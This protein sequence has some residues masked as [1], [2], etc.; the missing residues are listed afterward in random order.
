MRI[1]ARIVA[2]AVTVVGAGSAVAQP[3]PTVTLLTYNV[4][5]LPWPIATGRRPALEAIANRLVIMRREGRQ[6]HLVALQ[7]AFIPDAKAI[8]RT[9]GY[10][11]EAFGPAASEPGAQP[12]TPQDKAFLHDASFTI[13]ERAGKR[14]DSG[15]V[16]FSDYP[17]V[18]VHRMA[19]SM[20]AGY[21]CLA[22]K[23]VLA[24]LVA[25]PGL[26]TPLIVIDTHLNSA[27]ASGAPRTRS[28]Y[29]YD[30]QID[31]LNGFIA[32]LGYAGSPTLIAGDFNVGNHTDRKEYFTSHLL[33]SSSRLLA[34]EQSCAQSKECGGGTTG[35]VEESTARGKDWLLYKASKETAPLPINLE[36]C[37]G[38][39]PDGSMLSDHVGITVTYA[40][41][42]TPAGDRPV[43]VAVR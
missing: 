43:T 40:F 21:D 27:K 38:R 34:A 16:I 24:V 22:N 36:A 23:G 10:R 33:A 25:V 18:A 32:D 41:S 7:E 2:M 8:G 6:P 11:Y 3:M 30:R 4:K 19:Y 13:G 42:L 14:L 35:G 26:T 9:A 17:I 5:G 37:F 28:N 31:A 12:I 15:L 29:A 39:D 1:G 20:C